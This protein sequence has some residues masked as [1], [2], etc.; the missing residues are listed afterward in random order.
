[1][2]NL[3]KIAAVPGVP[4]PAP[5]SVWTFLSRELTLAT[6]RGKFLSYSGASMRVVSMPY[7]YH[8]GL[9]IP[10]VST[11]SEVPTIPKDPSPIVILDEPTEGEQGL[12]TATNPIFIRDESPEGLPHPLIVRPVL[13]R[14]GDHHIE[15]RAGGGMRSIWELSEGGVPCERFVSMFVQCPGCSHIVIGEYYEDHVCEL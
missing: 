14:Y 10:I 5:S 11:H 8:R 12:G 6:A 3:S 15:E 7:L 4:K 9:R 13:A 2:E 1:M